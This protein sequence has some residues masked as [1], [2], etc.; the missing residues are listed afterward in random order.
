MWR[1]VSL[2]SPLLLPPSS[3]RQPRHSKASLRGSEENLQQ[4]ACRDSTFSSSISSSVGESFSTTR[5]IP[6]TAPTKATVA[7]ALSFSDFL[8]FSFYLLSFFSLD[9]PFVATTAPGARLAKALSS[10]RAN[11]RPRLA[12]EDVAS[13]KKEKKKIQTLLL[14]APEIR[15]INALASIWASMELAESKML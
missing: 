15:S 9:K 13:P 5:K 6:T 8:S 12:P 7:L 11:W 4:R 2:A 10:A 1:A 3:I 14:S